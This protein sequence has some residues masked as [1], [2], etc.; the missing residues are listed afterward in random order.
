LITPA[1]TEDLKKLSPDQ[2][3]LLRN[4]LEDLLIK[5]AR[6][7]PNVF[8][9]LHFGKPPH[10]MHKE[11]QRIASDNQRFL[12]A[13]MRESGKSTQIT[14]LRAL[15]ELGRNPGLRIKIISISKQRAAKFVNAIGKHI[16]DPSR[17]GA[18]TAR[19]FPDLKPDR[20][21]SWSSEQINVVRP[22]EVLDQRDPSVEAW[23]I[24]SS[25]EGGRADILIFDDITSLASSVVE[26]RSREHIVEIF[27]GTWLD[28]KAGPNTRYWY[29]C[30]LWHE[31][32]CSAHVMKTPGW[33]SHV[34]AISKDFKHIET[35]YGAMFDLPYPAAGGGIWSTDALITEYKT[36]GAFFFNRSFRNNPTSIE[37]RLFKPHFFHGRKGKGGAIKYG[38]PP[39]HEMF[40][41]YPK[42]S[43][44]DLGISS[45]E[46]N[47]PSVIFTAAVADG[48][49]ENIPAGTRIV[50]DIR[51]GKWSSPDT[52]KQ[53]IE[54]YGELRPELIKVENNYYQQALIDWLQDIKGID[55]PIQG[56]FTG[57]QKLHPEHGIPLLAAEFERD[58]WHIPYEE[59]HEDTCSCV[60]CDWIREM[61]NFSMGSK[62]TDLVM[63][64]WFAQRAIK[65]SEEWTGGYGVW[66]V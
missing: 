2:Q 29:M 15:W 37:S 3:S 62:S 21:R 65:E 55:L 17:A 48:S 49:D 61:L 50:V 23:G 54:M 59:R 53:L 28:I 24:S 22:D 66:S 45:G 14:E 25:P 42:Y 30:T 57:S 13:A 63:A 6:E 46:H 18:I 39:W 27:R 20:N 33:N 47:K 58:K 35:N 4:N 7:D 9:A 10:P 44:V 56:H 52:A 43:G 38:V 60:F 5:K 41:G 1:T 12:L 19:V 26:P 36:R 51:K 8:I 32:D 34:F 16:I 11:F 31:E 64:N 40:K